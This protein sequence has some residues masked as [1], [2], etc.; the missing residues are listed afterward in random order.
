MSA[1]VAPAA[2]GEASVFLAGAGAGAGDGAGA[3]SAALFSSGGSSAATPAF[4]DLIQPSIVEAA[5]SGS[6]AIT[7]L[8][9]SI[10]AGRVFAVF[11]HSG[12][13]FSATSQLKIEKATTPSRKPRAAPNRNPSERSSAPILLSRIASDRRTVNRDTTISVTKNTAAA[14]TA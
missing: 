7:R 4:F 1:V 5:S 11:T 13:C 10:S 2:G 3:A 12:C 6:I 9:V 8:A 14:E